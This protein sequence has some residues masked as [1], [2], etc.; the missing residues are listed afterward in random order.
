[1]LLPFAT[2]SSVLLT[3][4]HSADETWIHTSCFRRLSLFRL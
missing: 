4:L 1:M 3:T 2:F